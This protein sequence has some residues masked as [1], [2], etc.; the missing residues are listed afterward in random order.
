M[1]YSIAEIA[2]ATGLDAAGDL[3]LAVSRPAE[4]GSAAQG[5]LALA[6][7]PDYEA[8]LRA[9]KA[10]AAVLWPGADWQALGLAAALFAPRPRLALAGFGDLFAPPPDLAPGI[11]PSAVIAPDAEIGA[12]AWIGPF[13]VVGAGALIGTGARIMPHV[14]IGGRARI[15]QGALLHPGVRIGA[16]V[17]I[18]KGFIAHPNA[19]IGAD[20]FSFVT[21]E[22]GAAERAQATGKIA[23]GQPQPQRRIAS[24]GAVEIGDDV[25]IG[26]CTAI[27]R[28]TVADTRIG[29]GTKIDNLVQVGH[30]V[31][32]GEACLICGQAGIAGSTTIGDRVILGGRSAVADHLRIGS[33]CVVAGGSLIGTHVP[34]GTVMMGTI[35]ALRH[36]VFSRQL[37]A[38]RRLPRLLDQVREIRKS[39]GL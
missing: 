27:D 8:A 20:G 1:T 37:R 31:R 35:P 14:S 32:I 19:V 4:P 38:L 6:M 18:G 39:L 30:N 9:S 16:G 12:D 22:P 24:L 2:R 21:P 28:G 13:A 23:P 15:G 3:S 36:D 17:R 10:R 26:A 25:E 33:D 5:D 29:S 34:P 11:H 7:S